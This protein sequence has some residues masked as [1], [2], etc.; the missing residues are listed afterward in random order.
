[1]RKNK[2]NQKFK[3]INSKIKGYDYDRWS[4]EEESEDKTI[5]DEKNKLGNLPPLE[6]DEEEVKQGKGFKILTPNKL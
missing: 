4:T 1:M 3:P 2:L 6:G 5:D